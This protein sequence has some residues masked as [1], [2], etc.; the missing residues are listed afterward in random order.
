MECCDARRLPRERAPARV[1]PAGQLPG[2]CQRAPSRLPVWHLPS[3]GCT[4]ARWHWHRRRLLAARNLGHTGSA[5]PVSKNTGHFGS[6]PLN[7]APSFLL[8]P[9]LSGAGSSFVAGFK[10]RG[11][12]YRGGY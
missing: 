8:T 11:G 2:P 7:Q 1:A 4:R 12:Y 5:S 9:P 3:L 10:S 6:G